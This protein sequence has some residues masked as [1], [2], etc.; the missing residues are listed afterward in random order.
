MARMTRKLG[1]LGIAL[2]MWDIWRRLPPSQRKLLI[3]TA[4]KQA[5][6]IAAAAVQARANMKNR[7]NR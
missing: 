3:A 5:P 4:R 7:K 1:P 2:T 6:K